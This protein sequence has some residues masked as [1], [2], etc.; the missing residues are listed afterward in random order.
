MQKIKSNL[1]HVRFA[2]LL[3]FFFSAES[4]FKNAGETSIVQLQLLVRKEFH[5]LAIQTKVEQDFGGFFHQ[6]ALVKR[7]V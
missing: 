6:S 2:C 1:L 5:H 4:C 3:A 7:K